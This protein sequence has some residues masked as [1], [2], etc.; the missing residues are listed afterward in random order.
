M[1]EPHIGVVTPVYNEQE[2]LFQLRDRLRVV[3]EALH[4]P[5]DV[6]LI[7]DGSTDSTPAILQRFAEEDGRWHGV[8][9]ARNFGH[10]AAIS[11][12]L[13]IARGDV[14]VVMDADL[15]DKP[16]AIPTLLEQWRRG[17]DTI[18]AIRTK[19]KEGMVRR[20]TYWLFYRVLNGL[21]PHTL[22]VDAGDFCLMSR[23]VVDALNALPETGRFVR[24]L[25]AW[26]GFRQ[27]GVEVERNARVAGTPKYTLA[28]LIRLAADGILDFSWGPLRAVSA[29]GFLSMIAALAYLVVILVMKFR[30]QIEV[31][32]WTSVIFLVVWFGGLTLTSLGVMGEYLGRAYLEVKRRP[33]FIIA[34]TTDRLA[35]DGHATPARSMPVSRT[36]REHPGGGYATTTPLSPGH[37]VVVQHGSE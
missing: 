7:D 32:G 1:T 25:R 35:P 2:C 16:E 27:I 19:R 26:V 22:P 34:E 5:Y 15:Q 36:G 10:Q 14:I 20:M 8:T 23:R 11:A 21:S 31:V 24:G 9:L 33:T 4:L 3:L 18:Y 28:K 37:R 17:Y 30:G 12:G 29:F 6:Y 13:S